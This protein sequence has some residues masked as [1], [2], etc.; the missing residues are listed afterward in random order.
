MR[1]IR[2]SGNVFRD[3]RVP[4]AE[5]EQWK[6]LLAARICAALARRGGSLREVARQT[7]LWASDLS[8]IRRAKL[9]RFTIDR[10]IRLLGRLTA[11]DAE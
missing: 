1:L 3:L 6:S 7:G 8:R 5:V 4:D 11:E 10:L 2:G 9:G